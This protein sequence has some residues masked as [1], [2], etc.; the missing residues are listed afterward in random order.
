MVRL[1][2]LMSLNDATNCFNFADRSSFTMNIEET[3]DLS[4][5]NS[6]EE[7]HFSKILSLMPHYN[8]ESFESDKSNQPLLDEEMIACQ[9]TSLV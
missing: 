3:A 4:A 8:K 9:L 5:G 2:G 7:V 6:S 1:A